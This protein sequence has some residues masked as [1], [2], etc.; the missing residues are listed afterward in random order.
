MENAHSNQQSGAD[1][2]GIWRRRKWIGIGLFLLTFVPASTFV[3]SLPKMYRASATLAVSDADGSGSVDF[4]GQAKIPLSAVTNQVLSRNN[5]EA[6]IA[7]LKLFPKQRARKTVSGSAL[8]D[9]MRKNI[10][11][12]KQEIRDSRGVPQALSFTVS[13]DAWDPETSAIVANRLAKSYQSTANSMRVDQALS[14]AEALS[15]SMAVIR[16]KLE[17]QQAH[18]E[19]F[20][21][22]HAGELPQQQQVSLA[23]L[24]HLYNS[25]Q[26]LQTRQLDAI[27]Q[28]AE[29]LKSTNVSGGANLA[30]LEQKLYNLRLQYTD[31]YPDIVE[32][33]KQI[34][35]LKSNQATGGA[36]A[37]ADSTGLAQSQLSSVNTDLKRMQSQEKKIKSQINEYQNRLEMLPLTSQKLEAM[38]QTNSQTSD[39]YSALLKRYDQARIA[40]VTG[41][42]GNSPFSILESALPPTAPVGPESLRI[43]IMFLLLCI[44]IAAAA[45]TIAEKR[46][47]SFHTLDELR[48]FTSVPVLTTVPFIHGRGSR[49]KRLTHAGAAVVLVVCGVLI[50]SGGAY[51]AGHSNQ[52]FTQKFSSHK[53]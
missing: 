16:K 9:F 8:A 3:W 47:T 41:G 44:V 49:V 26:T 34:A 53:S 52:S 27:K 39:I 2:G 4:G 42:K 45:M 11:I 33:K 13:Y 21:S 46:D 40:A 36:A 17:Q 7:E 30:Q 29:L 20:S 31:Q 18:I 24:G 15:S 32:L 10:K 23:T 14:T 6:I 48:K 5:L 35:A 1:I 51:V 28:R 38:N 50:L 22:A 19:K 37:D 12:D 43:E 25:L